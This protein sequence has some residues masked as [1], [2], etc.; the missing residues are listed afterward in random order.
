MAAFTSG[1]KLRGWLGPDSLVSGVPPSPR[2]GDHKRII[3]I[4]IYSYDLSWIVWV[5][6]SFNRIDASAFHTQLALMNFSQKAG[7]L[8]WSAFQLLLI[9]LPP[10]R[11]RAHTDELTSTNTH[12]SQAYR[13]SQNT[14]PRYLHALHIFITAAAASNI[15]LMISI[16]T[17]STPIIISYMERWC[18]AG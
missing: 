12:L 7:T 15:V 5:D 10:F 6:S 9:S 16:I 8:L 4:S 17:T 11:Q 13:H 18:L 2:D 3:C 14:T 1:A